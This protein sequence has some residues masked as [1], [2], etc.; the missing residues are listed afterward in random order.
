MNTIDVIVVLIAIAVFR[1]IYLQFLREPKI[2]SQWQEY[3]KDPFEYRKVFTVQEIKKG[4]VLIKRTDNRQSFHESHSMTIYT[5]KT[6]YRRI[7]DTCPTDPVLAV[8]Q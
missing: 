8:T 2:G 1:F 6:K 5:L 4:H 7:K 3:H